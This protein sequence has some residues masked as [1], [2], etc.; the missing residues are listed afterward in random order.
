MRFFR[1]IFVDVKDIIRPIS[2]VYI[3]LYLSIFFAL[4]AL[5]KLSWEPLQ[6]SVIWLAAAVVCNSIERNVK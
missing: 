3:L 4:V 2:R 5:V 1:D 6:I